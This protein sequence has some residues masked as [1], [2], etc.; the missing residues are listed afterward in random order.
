[1][2]EPRTRLAQEL[3]ALKYRSPGES[4]KE[5]QNRFA[6]ALADNDAE[7]RVT[8]LK[9]AKL[10]KEDFIKLFTVTNGKPVTIR[11]L[12]PPFHEFLP[13]ELEIRQ[14]TWL[15]ILNPEAT[16]LNTDI[17]RKVIFYQESNPMLGLRT[18]DPRPDG[19]PGRHQF[20][21]QARPRIGVPGYDPG[22]DRGARPAADGPEKRNPA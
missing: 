5:A 4:F 20:H 17:L 1:M 21:G 7:R 3:H 14:R 11:L 18:G 2:C 22:T 15:Q 12:D 10:Q 13:G 16:Q 19:H 9:M 6:S 8:L